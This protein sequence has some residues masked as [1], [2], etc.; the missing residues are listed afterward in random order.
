H[1]GHSAEGVE[2]HLG[3]QAADIVMREVLLVVTVRGIRH[4]GELIDPRIQDK[5]RQSLKVVLMLDE[6]GGE[7]I[8]QRLVGSGIGGT[9]VVLGLDQATAEVVFPEAVGCQAGK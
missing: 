1:L 2:Q 8:Q 7:V 5:P 9:K 3:G 6:L 4:T